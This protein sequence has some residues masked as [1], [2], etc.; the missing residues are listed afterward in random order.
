[1]QLDEDLIALWEGQRKTFRNIVSNNVEPRYLEVWKRKQLET[2]PGANPLVF[3][4]IDVAIVEAVGNLGIH[5]FANQEVRFPVDYELIHITPLA[6]GALD[7]VHF[8]QQLQLPRI[9]PAESAQHVGVQTA[10]CVA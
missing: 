9:Q 4:T 7:V 10:L 6:A 5:P 1:M 3:R 2:E 8:T